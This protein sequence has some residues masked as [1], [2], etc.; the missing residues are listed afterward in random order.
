MA[1]EI[2]GKGFL[3]LILI[4]I[5]RIP[6]QYIVYHARH[7]H[8]LS[9]INAIFTEIRINIMKLLRICLLFLIVLPNVY[10][11]PKI[12]IADLLGLLLL[13][14]ISDVSSAVNPFA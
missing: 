9:N 14:L 3:D 5:P 2:Q 4:V 8:T 6:I 13:A 7:R 1:W 12:I 10:V 11:V